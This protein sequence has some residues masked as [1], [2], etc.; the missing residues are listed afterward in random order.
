M[1]TAQRGRGGGEK[2]KAKPGKM[3]ADEQVFC[4]PEV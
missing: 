1:M 2:L 4:A 3:K